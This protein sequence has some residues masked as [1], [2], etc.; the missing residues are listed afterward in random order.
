MGEF[1]LIQH[2]DAAPKRRPRSTV[3]RVHVA[4]GIDVRASA[5]DRRMNDKTGGID[6]VVCRL[7]WNPLVVDQDQIA[8]LDEGKVL[9]IRIYFNSISNK[10][11]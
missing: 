8:R 7:L 1:T 9:G 3:G 6:L 4:H 10:S 11:N 5:V 2:F